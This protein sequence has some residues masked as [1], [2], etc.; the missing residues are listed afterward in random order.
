MPKKATKSKAKPKTANRPKR[1]LKAGQVVEMSGTYQSETSK[2][3]MTLVKGDAAPP[4]PLKNERW[5]KVVEMAKPSQLAANNP[6]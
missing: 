4:T 5:N 1:T 6:T 3:R 2:T